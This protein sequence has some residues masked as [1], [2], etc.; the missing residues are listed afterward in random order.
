[1]EPSGE[2]T[3]SFTFRGSNSVI[4][5]QRKQLLF[6]FRGSNSVIH[7]QRKQLL[8][9]FRGSNSV[10]HLRASCHLQGKL[11]FTFRGSNSVTFRGSNSV[12]HLQGK[13][14]CHSPSGEATLLFLFL[15]P[16]SMGVNSQRK[17]VGANLELTPFRRSFF[18]HRDVNRKSKKY[19][20]IVKMPDKHEGAL[21][22]L[23]APE[24]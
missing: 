7:L 24:S 1:M 11:S 8:F 15:L 4:H 10:I 12:T 18:S 9:T 14:L 22:H 19:F 16:F 23:K 3:L 2:A 6:T 13:Q 20:P 5:L 17:A 21:I